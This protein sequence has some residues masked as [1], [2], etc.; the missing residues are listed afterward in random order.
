MTSATNKEYDHRWSFFNP[1]NITFGAGQL[2]QLSALVASER[3]LLV[4][5]K[6]ATK[7]GLT[8]SIRELMPSTDLVV[9]DEVSSNPEIDDVESYCRQFSDDGITEIVAV[10]GGSSIDMAK[11]LSAGL[12]L[13]RKQQTVSNAIADPTLLTS[14]TPVPLIAI[15]T[16]SGTGSEATPFA[17][18]W[19]KADKHKS[20]L[21]GKEL[22]ATQAIV[23]PS[24]TLTLPLE[25]TLFTA[26]DA[27]SHAFESIWSQQCT[28]VT[29]SF[30]VRSIQLI[31]ESL[32]ELLEKLDSLSLRSDIAEASLLA[33]LAISNTKTALAH[34]MSYPIT[35]HHAMPHGLACS[36]TL[37]ALLD[38]NLGEDDGR[39]K[40]LAHALGL[41]STG[42]LSDRL[43]DFLT[44]L[45]VREYVRRYISDSGDLV[46]LAGEM[47]APGRADNNLRAAKLSDVENIIL[48][49]C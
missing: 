23:D 40:R 26:L 12:T 41:S 3:T 8:D 36:F 34:A 48:S 15:P 20:S 2:S 16:T 10:G 28:P 17:T 19:N 38:F 5:T 4:T 9:L 42:A 37:P 45:K 35:I 46:C 1:V 39:L 22:Y 31:F 30:A 25:T 43:S 24:L 29:M 13:L 47:F 14:L 11:A 21:S 18:L 27:L 32:P 7:R 49:A 33:G 6:G 44:E